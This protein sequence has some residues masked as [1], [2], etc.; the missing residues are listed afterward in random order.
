MAYKHGVYVLETETSLVAP[1]E[2]TAGLQ[3]VFGTAPIH[4]TANPNAAVNKPILCYSYAEAA[5]ALGYSDEWDKF[6]LCQSMAAC[7]KVFNVAPVIFVNVLDQ[8]NAAHITANAEE[9]VTPTNS[10]ATYTKDYVLLSTLVVKKETTTLVNG[11]DYIA[12]HDANGHVLITLVSVLAKAATAL[13]VAS[14]SLKPSGVTAADIIGGIDV[15]TGAETGLSLIR[16]IYPKFGMTPGLI[17]SPGWS[18]G[19]TVAAAMQAACEDINGCFNCEAIIDIDSSSAG[20]TLYSDVKTIKESTG[21]DSAHA[22][23]CWPMAKIGAQLFYMSALMGA[24]TAYTDAN[25]SDVPNISPSNKSLGITATVLADGT[26]VLLDQEQANTVNGYGVLTAVNFNGYKSWGNN[27]AAYPS[28]T[29]PKD[30]WFAVRRFFSWW[31]NSFILTYFQKVDA[32]ANYRLI[33]SIVD[34]ENI[35]GNSYQARGYCA[36]AKIVFLESENPTADIL[37]GAIRFHMYLAPYTPAENIELVLEFD[38]AALAAALTGG[39]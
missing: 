30:R 29:D 7:F 10:Q 5:T 21:V 25:N 13:L 26:E 8:S 39:E 12:T 36:E 3:V 28:T 24:L 33:E 16:Q 14:S 4:L 38:P 31:G 11:T 32:P 35:R 22:L 2:G 18:H 1:I 19:A 6:T 15:E 23:A 27:T 20:A 9:S 17:L 34:S 37:N